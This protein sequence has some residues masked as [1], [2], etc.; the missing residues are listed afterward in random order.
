M[1]IIHVDYSVRMGY[2]A[3]KNNVQEYKVCQND[4]DLRFEF[5]EQLVTSS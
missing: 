2:W 4:T 1:K 5:Y 3:L